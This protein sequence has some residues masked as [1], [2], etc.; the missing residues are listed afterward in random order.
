[1]GVAGGAHLGGVGVED[2][3]VV[4]L[5]VL[6]ENLVKLRI[7]CVT[8]GGACLLCHLDT[9]VWHE[10][11]LQRLIGLKTY[12]LLEILLRLV[13]I[14]CAVSGDAGNDLGLHIEHAAL[15]TLFLLKC[16]Y[17]VPKLLCR[18]GRTSK[19]AGITIINGVVLLDE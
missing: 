17:L 2:G 5:V 12:D 7:R 1:M 11:S 18:F 10:C 8:I 6:G 13:D 15:C 4:G 16:L 3:L 14:C 9:A 19:E